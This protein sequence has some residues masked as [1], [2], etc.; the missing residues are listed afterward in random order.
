MHP[1]PLYNFVNQHLSGHFNAS[2]GVTPPWF[3]LGC[4]C[5]FNPKSLRNR[6]EPRNTYLINRG[7]L[8]ERVVLREVWIR[9]NQH[10]GGELTCA[11]KSGFVKTPSKAEESLRGGRHPEDVMSVWSGT[12]YGPKIWQTWLTLNILETLHNQ[13]YFGGTQGRRTLKIELQTLRPSQVN[14]RCSVVRSTRLRRWE[15]ER[16]PYTQKRG[17]ERQIFLQHKSI[18][19]GTSQ[20]GTHKSEPS[21]HGDPGGVGGAGASGEIGGQ[22]GDGEGPKVNMNDFHSGR[23]KRVSGGTGGAGGDGLKVGGQDE[24]GPAG[25][26]DALVKVQ[27]IENLEHPLV[28]GAGRGTV[29]HRTCWITFF[30]PVTSKNQELTPVFIHPKSEQDKNK[31]RFPELCKSKCVVFAPIEYNPK[32]GK[33]RG[34]LEN[35]K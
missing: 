9:K 21:P 5:H 26:W 30:S 11:P 8:L 22:G 19:A 14:D 32:A 16:W 1:E 28:S 2:G 34:S 27:A 12:G 13:G 25:V 31:I 3:N 18:R 35:Q 24:T 23:V 15:L 10:K 6:E 20:F 17:L 4:N 7:Y 33:I 29:V